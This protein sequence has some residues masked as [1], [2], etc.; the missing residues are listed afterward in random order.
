MALLATTGLLMGVLAPTL[1]AA[2]PP[3][4]PPG[5][6]KIA[7]TLAAGLDQQDTQDFWV[8]FTER[9]DNS[10]ARDIQDWGERGRYVHTRLTATAE[11]SQAAVRAQLDE[12]GVDYRAHW[13]VN[14]ILVEDGTAE[15]ARTLAANTAVRQ[16]IPTRT[17]QTPDPI[18]GTA[19]AEVDDVEWGV[20]NINADD[21]WEQYGVTGDG[22][23]V[24]SIDTG[25]QYDHPAL[26]A[27]Y[28]GNTG[29]GT[30][31]HN[32]NWYDAA[33]AC[34]GDAPCDNDGH[35][36]HTTGT[37]VG[38]DGA[39]NKIGVAPGARWIE[40]NGCCP[41]DAAIVASGEWFLAPRDLTDAP[42]TADPAK[43]PHVIN[44][45]WG[46]GS[47]T[48][49]P[50][51]P[52]V[53]QAWT[54]AGMFGVFANGNNGPSCRTSG[55]PGSQT[56]E[57]S[58]GS[59]DVANQI[60]SFSSRGA[61]QNG[62]IKPNISAPGSDVR[63]AWPG[64]TY[65]TI[66]GTSMA[67]PHVAGA[68]ALLWSAYPDM[69]GDVDGTRL[70]LNI[71]AINTY[72]GQC[73]GD[74]EYNNV[75]GEGRL[76]A[77]ALV[78]AGA[79]GT[80]RLEGVVRDEAGEPMAGVAVRAEGPV[81]RSARTRADGTFSFQLVA[82]SYDMTVTGPFGYGS[83][84]R[85]VTV[86]R[87]TTFRHDVTLTPSERVAV[88]GVVRDGSGQGWP[89][90]A[91]VVVTHE[92]GFRAAAT[93]DQETGA[94]RLAVVPGATYTMT[95][96]TGTPGYEPYRATITVDTEDLVRDVDLSVSFACTAPGYEVERDG[97]WERFDR[98]TSWRATTVDPRYPGFDGRVGWVFNDPGK[99][100]NRTGGAGGF[101]IVDSDHLGE[102]RVQDTYLTS[103]SFNLT[104][105]Q[106]AAVEFG[107]DLRPAVNSDA[108]VD[109]STDGGRT[110]TTVWQ[111]TGFPGAD[112]PGSQA[113]RLPDAAGKRDV[114]LR[115]HYEGQWS[116]WWAVDDV[117]VGNR[118]CTPVS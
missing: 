60:S 102:K 75:F 45:S 83:D 18:A 40:A 114:R 113:V 12:R 58:V 90:G 115:F 63:S 49:S 101:A 19:V 33:N 118:T 109:L 5:A 20:A 31:D 65:N 50:F 106:D 54:D 61:G 35:G 10:A 112:G 24:A 67:T 56:S 81:A 43:R 34:E 51:M 84:A 105:R 14:A 80:S 8:H 66:S 32:Y 74:E 73:G 99:R 1:A 79:T 76:D 117:F 29:N 48:D 100:T 6:G 38:G 4:P 69:I 89:L 108:S 26:V 116:G 27:Q 94:Y 91:E 53:L 41:S 62:T 3:A 78:T 13:I 11:R 25:A 36:T 2:A 47:P 111:R 22:I 21:V 98:G 55:S 7:P 44:N 92:S 46:S 68:V 9:A 23:T 88:S 42:E 77:L 17:Y 71:T 72:D 16:L 103:P 85:T 110:W 59:Y 97:Q 96:A 87:D 107:T 86:A 15:L 37:M 30:F 93:S 70:L 82:G 57:Y 104:G 28:R 52:E 39:T 64:G 95:V